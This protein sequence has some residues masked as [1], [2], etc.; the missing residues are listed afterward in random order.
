LRD[1]DREAVPGLDGQC[2]KPAYRCITGLEDDKSSSGFCGTADPVVTRL[3]LAG[4]GVEH[5][6][7]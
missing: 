3:A 4:I 1:S 6:E 2:S 7:A 5:P